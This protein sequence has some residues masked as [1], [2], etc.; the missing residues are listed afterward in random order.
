MRRLRLA[1]P[2][3]LAVALPLA[4]AMAE[5][6]QVVRAG[7]LMAQPFIDAAKAGP[8]T[9]NQGVTVLKRQ[10]G[11][12]QVAADGGKTGW[13]RALN[14]RLAAGAGPVPVP[15]VGPRLAL[16]G[17][18]RGPLEPAGLAGRKSKLQTGSSRQ[19]VT[20]G[21][22]GLDEENIRQASFDAEQLDKLNALGASPEQARTMAAADK[23]AEN[24]VDYLKKGKVK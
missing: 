21:V 12:V 19:T 5:R 18:A 14:L 6:A 13:V 3:L 23:L 16:Q 22:K 7:D 2:V 15:R 10:G 1:L 20:T 24:K 8:L 4:P 11:W 9:A 17:G